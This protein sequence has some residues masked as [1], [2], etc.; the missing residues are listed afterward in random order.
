MLLSENSAAEWGSLDQTAGF[1]VNDEQHV[2]LGEKRTRGNNS[3]WES[4]V[5]KNTTRVQILWE[6][7]G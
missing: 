7:G 1:G 6:T 4:G 2:G 3:E 5:G